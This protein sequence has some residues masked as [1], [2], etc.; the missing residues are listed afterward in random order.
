[1]LN[2]NKARIFHSNLFIFLFLM[3]AHVCVHKTAVVDLGE[4]PGGACPPAYFG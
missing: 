3:L 4:R 1:M 2:D